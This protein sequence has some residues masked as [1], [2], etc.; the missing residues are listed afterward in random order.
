M[1]F[2]VGAQLKSYP[3]LAVWLDDY[4][5]GRAQGDTELEILGGKLTTD[6]AS[7]ASSCVD[8]AVQPFLL[9]TGLSQTSGE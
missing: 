6:E 7:E 1:H 4:R 8:H 5:K 9:S 2:H 3:H